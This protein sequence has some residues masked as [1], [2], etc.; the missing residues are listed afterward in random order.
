MK[1][2]V[3]VSRIRVEEKLLFEELAKRGIE[4]DRLYDNELIFHLEDK[5][6]S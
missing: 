1:F 3:L 2:G 4:F 6:L 5:P